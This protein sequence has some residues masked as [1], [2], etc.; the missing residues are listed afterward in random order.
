[1]TEWRKIILAVLTALA[2]AGAVRADMVSPSAEPSVRADSSQTCPPADPAP[3]AMPIAG[4]LSGLM[5]LGFGTVK[6][7]PQGPS[8]AAQTAEIPP[9]RILSDRQNSVHL[10]LYA[11]LSLGLCKSVPWVRKVSFGVIPQWYHD[12][13]PFQIGHSHAIAPDCLGSVPVVCFVQPDRRAANLV[14][15]NRPGIVVSLWRESQFAS[16]AF[17]LRGPPVLISYVSLA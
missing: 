10:C 6:F 13:G 2:L 17:A 16:A 8:D 12:G 5:N 4:D 11:L 15:Q 3:A 9:A 1:M 7:L 14:T